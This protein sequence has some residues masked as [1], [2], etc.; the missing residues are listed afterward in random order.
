MRGPLGVVAAVAVAAAA[1]FGLP[2]AASADLTLPSITATPLPSVSVPLPSVSTTP[3]PLPTSTTGSTPLPSLPGSGTPLP[4]STSPGTGGG[5]GGSGATGGDA[6]G[7]TGGGGSGALT[8]AAGTA[9]ATAEEL[10]QRARRARAATPLIAGTARARDLID[11]ESSPRLLE[12]SRDFLAADQGIAEIARQK[13]VMARLKQEAAETAAVYRALGYDILTAQG[14]ADLMHER[15]DTLRRAVA[16]SVRT[17]YASG[18]PSTDPLTASGIADALQ[19][20]SDGGA[21]ADLRVGS[22]TVQRDE[23]RAAFDRLAEGYA[24]AKRRLDDANRRLAALS[25]DRAVALQSVQAAEGSDMARHRARIAESG[26]LGAQIRAASQRLARN[27]QTVTG[28]GEFVSPLAGPVTSAYGMRVHPILG[29][30]KL[31][32][33]IDVGATGTI[34]APDSGRVIM[35][36]TSTAYGNFT[37][38]DHGVIDGRRVT[39]AYAHQAQFLVREGQAVAKGEAIGIV[40]STGYSTGPHLHFEVREDGALVDPM[41]WLRAQS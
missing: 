25:R 6:T 20:F 23:V 29:Y 22:L 15:Y 3:L 18:Q 37:V 24:E 40:G 2:G 33:G 32:T 36:I 41:T 21:R 28:S 26:E 30:A 31:H 27:G 11:D 19:R 39:T 9:G 16:D 8:G 10:R 34:V 1:G 17:A 14:R 7:A 12:A 4:G 5:S 13:R 35:T 38:I